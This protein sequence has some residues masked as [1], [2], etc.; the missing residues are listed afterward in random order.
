MESNHRT[1]SPD[2]ISIR[3]HLHKW[4]DCL[5]SARATRYLSR[6]NGTTG[7]VCLAS[8][9]VLRSSIDVVRICT[10]HESSYYRL[11]HHEF[12]QGPFCSDTLRYL[13]CNLRPSFQWL[14][15]LSPAPSSPIQAHTLITVLPYWFC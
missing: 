15:Y 9:T 8:R 14:A 3:P 11:C 7:V 4:A 6:G 13:G 12:R 1:L 2:A 10:P 5:T